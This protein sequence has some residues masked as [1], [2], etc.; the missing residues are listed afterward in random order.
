M[1]RWWQRGDLRRSGPRPAGRRLQLG[2]QVLGVVAHLSSLPV[3]GVG[4][5]LVGR[6]VIWLAAALPL[7]PLL[8]LVLGRQ[9][10][11]GVQAQ[12]TEALN[13]SL[14]IALAALGA[15]VG[16]SLVGRTEW[17]LLVLP[18]LVL[19]VLVVFVNWLVLLTLAA[20]EA[21]RGVAFAYPA[22]LR[23]VPAPSGSGWPRVRAG[24]RRPR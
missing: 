14:T 11:R 22:I 6:P 20:I 7:G 1:Q 9:A 24:L 12:A 17:S 4:M 3:A 2:E 23:P 10:P 21:G 8:V 15:G 5:L 18:V 16:L 13:F 19:L